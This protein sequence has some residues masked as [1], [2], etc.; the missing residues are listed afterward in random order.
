MNKP[1]WIDAFDAQILLHVVTTPAKPSYRFS[2][3]L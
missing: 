1:T 2:S 3:R